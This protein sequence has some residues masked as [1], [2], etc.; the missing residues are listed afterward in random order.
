M[1]RKLKRTH[2]FSK[3]VSSLLYAY[4]DVASP[5]PQTVTCLD[6]VI[7][8]YLVDICHKAYKVSKYSNR[9]KVKLEDFKF[10]L[11]NDP[12]KLGRADELI[13]TNKLITE[14]KKQ[15]NETDTSVSKTFKDEATSKSTS[16]PADNVNDD[17]HGNTN[18]ELAD[19]SATA[20]HKDEEDE[21][22]VIEESDEEHDEEEVDE[23]G[24][25]DD[26]N[27]DNDEQTSKT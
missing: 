22:E 5:L 20:E 14:A 13:A 18:I 10:V 4:G 9:S 6:E 12:I 21:D 8:S 15:F 27:V 3:D 2:L 11:K 1:S 26:T 19:A 17:V 16:N 23:D 24:D 7:S 25:E